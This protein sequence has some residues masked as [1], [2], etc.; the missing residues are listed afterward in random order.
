M[1]NPTS[2]G[3]PRQDMNFQ[4]NNTN[5]KLPNPANFKIVKCKSFERGILKKFI[6]NNLF[7]F[8]RK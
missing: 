8:L 2:Q 6:I 4:N 1:F 7:T 3:S 5:K